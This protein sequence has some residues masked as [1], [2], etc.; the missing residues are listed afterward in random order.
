MGTRSALN[1]AA[2]ETM[3]GL[4]GL[5]N[6]IALVDQD[7]T[8]IQAPVC[9]FSN[10]I[11]V[12]AATLTLAYATH[13]ARPVIQLQACV[14]TLPAIGVVGQTLWVINGAADGTL[15]TIVIDGSDKFLWDVAGAA[16]TDSK[17]LYN[18]ALTAKKGDYIKLAY[19]AAAGWIISEMGG[20]WVDE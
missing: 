2:K 12:D 19:G 9:N 11:E 4:V 13:C 17:D 6:N 5:S 1:K 15:M 18:T 8:W 14:F 20:T 16:G 3:T 7:N 10:A